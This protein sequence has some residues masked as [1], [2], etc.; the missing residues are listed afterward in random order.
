[1]KKDKI[2][3]EKSTLVELLKELKKKK[4]YKVK[5]IEKI[6]YKPKINNFII[7]KKKIG[8]IIDGYIYYPVNGKFVNSGK[9][10]R[11][12]N[13]FNYLKKLKKLEKV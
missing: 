13:F 3:F 8:K 10:Y 11:V 12:S 9:R 7:K 5:K 4:V 6:K 2:K 1:M